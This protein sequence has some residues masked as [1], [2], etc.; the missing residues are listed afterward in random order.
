ML[1]ALKLIDRILT[2]STLAAAI[3][4]LLLMT[5]VAFYQVITRFVLS[6]PAAWS[7]VTAR[8]LNIWMIYLGLVATCRYGALMAVDTLISRLHGRMRAALV[9]FITI[10]TV[11]LFS[12]MAWYGVELVQ[13]VRFQVL[14]GAVNPFTGGRISISVMYAALPVGLGLSV[15]ATLIHMVEELQRIF[16]G[17]SPLAQELPVAHRTLEV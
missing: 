2:R 7:E 17:Q 11:V 5:A 12:V 14:A 9:V 13:R 15:L 6:E 16:R 8:T 3:I 10:L 1:K 4:L